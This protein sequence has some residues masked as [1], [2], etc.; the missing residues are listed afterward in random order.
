MDTVR[1][2]RLAAEARSI[3]ARLLAI[4]AG[5]WL[6]VSAFLWPHTEAQRGS[7][8]VAGFVIVAAALGGRAPH[9]RVVLAVAAAWLFVASFALS[10][11]AIDTIASDL[12][13]AVAVFASSAFDGAPRAVPPRTVEHR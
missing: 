1:E 12:F 6:F 7:C 3:G 10:T 8:F 2:S 9:M 13:V 5:T 11:L 4:S